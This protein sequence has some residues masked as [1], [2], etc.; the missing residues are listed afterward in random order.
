MVKN[1]IMNILIQLIQKNKLNL[2]KWL[3][4]EENKK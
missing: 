3:E 2:S 1:I 4:V